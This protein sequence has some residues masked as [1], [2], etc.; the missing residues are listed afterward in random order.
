GKDP[1]GRE[2]LRVSEEILRGAGLQVEVREDA[3]V[4]L[5]R[6]HPEATL[7]LSG[8]VDVVP[9]GSGWERDPHGGE[10]AENRLWGRGACDMLGSVA[11]FLRLAQARPD[12]PFGIALTT[13]EET[14]MKG[15]EALVQ[16][17][18]LASFQAAVV[19]EPTDFEIGVAEKGVLWLRLT[20]EG[21]SAHASMPEKG[22]N[23]I[24]ALVAGLGRLHG[25]SLGPRHVL[26]G[27]PTMSLGRLVGGT[28]VNMVPDHAMAELDIRYC[29]PATRDG[30]LAAI[31]EALRQSGE[32]IRIEIISDHAPFEAAPTSRL[33]KAAEGALRAVRG[34]PRAVGLPY[35]TEASKF[36]SLG[37]DLI[38]LGPGERGLAHTNRESIALQD[39]EDGYLLYEA[40]VERYAK[41][42][43]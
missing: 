9:E 32:T 22:K 38:I 21:R 39:L 26:L 19:G 23:A 33:G 30:I 10:V 24:A 6:T 27:A 36:V 15:A 1:T 13:D 16:Q 29:P 25:V 28:A 42:G 4:L 12:L 43:R 20:A 40:L 8:H 37:M 34:N 31:E 35:G 5:A 18:M 14:G 3:G 7:L 11:C 41:G 2:A 17:G